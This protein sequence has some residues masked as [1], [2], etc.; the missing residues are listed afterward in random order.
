MDWSR[1]KT[2]FILSFLVLDFYL[3]YQF[4]NTKNE[5]NYEL[6][7]EVKIEDKLKNDEI[8]Y[9]ELPEAAQKERYLS[10]KP[11]EFSKEESKQ[12]TAGNAERT[13]LRVTLEKPIKLSGKFESSELGPFIKGFVPYGD[14]YQF[15]E[16][17]D[18]SKTIVYF[19]QYQ[20]KTFY[21]NLNGK[22]TF[23]YNDQNEVYAYDQ[24][25]LEVQEELA[26][27]QEVLP[28]LSA[29]D[30]LYKKGLLKPKSKIT[31]VKLGYSTLVQLTASQV[32]APTWRIEVDNKENLF[33]QAFEGQVIQFGNEENKTTE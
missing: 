10:V 19:Q 1:I 27:R 3:V 29:I 23:H 25:Y 17:D 6:L 9:K 20:G 4:M 30:T 14:D 13:S 7:K 11:K 16:K 5:A 33:V 8:T 2:I 22:L 15:W 12:Q 24:T 21:N 32:L 28:A 18:H 26:E 31:N